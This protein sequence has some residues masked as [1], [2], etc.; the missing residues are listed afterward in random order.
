[1]AK[2]WTPNAE[3]KALIVESGFVIRD[4][5]VTELFPQVEFY[6]AEK[7]WKLGIAINR[8]RVMFNPL[9]TTYSDRRQAGK[10]VHE[11][12][13]V[14]QYI[15]Y[16]WVGFIATYTWE[17]IRSGFSYERMKAFGMEKEA[18]NTELKFRML[19]A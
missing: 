9:I 10:I 8:N 2:R 14:A 17:W 5:P 15:D 16:G 1:M 19:I 13:H 11:L 3:V 12:T 18:I 7:F 4:K 6:L